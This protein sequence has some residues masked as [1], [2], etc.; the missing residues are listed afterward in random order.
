MNMMKDLSAENVLELLI[1]LLT[2][3]IDD[4]KDYGNVEG[5]LYQYGERVAYTECLECIQQWE[6]AAE[7][8]IDFDIEEKYPL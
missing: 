8:G 4:L 7:Y 2:D 5:E 6:K 1:H 3:H